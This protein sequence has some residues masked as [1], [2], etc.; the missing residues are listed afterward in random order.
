MF[1]VVTPD[2][3][4]GKALLDLDRILDTSL[5]RIA[6][7]KRRIVEIQRGRSDGLSYTEIVDAARSPLLVQLI[8]ESTQMLDGYGARVRRAEALA[9]HAEG[10]TMEEIAERFG[11]TRQRVSALLRVARRDSSDS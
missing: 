11:V 3:S 10:M 4:L 9:L 5:E 1:R 6:Q 8:T 2:D 7:I